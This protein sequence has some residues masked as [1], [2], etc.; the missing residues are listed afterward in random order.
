M[1]KD[2]T[3]LRAAITLLRSIRNR[4]ALV[5]HPLVKV[6]ARRHNEFAERLPEIVA[7]LLD[8]LSLESEQ[9]RRRFAVLRRSD[10]ERESHAAIARDDESVA[11]PVLSRP[12]RGA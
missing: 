11:Q 4:H 7:S 3:Q 2:Q 9:H 5:R 8:E 10:I 6:G 12:A 1:Q